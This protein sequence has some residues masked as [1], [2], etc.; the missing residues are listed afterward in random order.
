MWSGNIFN[1]IQLEKMLSLFVAEDN[2]WEELEKWCKE[3]MIYSDFRWQAHHITLQSWARGP[4]SPPP[5]WVTRGV[6]S[7]QCFRKINFVVK[8]KWIE[9]NLGWEEAVVVELL[10]TVAGRKRERGLP[11]ISGFLAYCVTRYN[12]LLVSI[13]CWEIIPY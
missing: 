11:K 6:L 12:M 1:H 13:R 8:Q 4:V 2:K 3:W 9:V 7:K 5:G 10:W